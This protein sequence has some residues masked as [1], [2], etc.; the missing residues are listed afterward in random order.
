[1]YFRLVDTGVCRLVCG[2]RVGGPDCL[3]GLFQQRVLFQRHMLV[4]S[5]CR[6]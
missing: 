5:V 6:I 3:Q 1:M 4:R 2:R